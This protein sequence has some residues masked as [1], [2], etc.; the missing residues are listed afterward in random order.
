MS[1]EYPVSPAV[2]V[3]RLSDAGYPPQKVE[4][5]IE[6]RV[7]Y[8]ALYRWKNG[9]AQPQRSADYRAV[10]DLAVAVGVDITP[11]TPDNPDETSAA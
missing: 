2:L 9:E 1:R 5:M 4:S 3:N 8:R 10:Y 11:D 7:S 6:A